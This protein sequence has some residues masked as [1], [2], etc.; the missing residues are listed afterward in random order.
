MLRS[1]ARPAFAATV[2][3]VLAC[4]V[5]NA[6]DIPAKLEMNAFVKIEP[7]QADLVIRV[8]LYLVT[9][10]GFPMNG[11][12]ID[13]AASGP[14][15]ERTLTAIAT[16]IGIW[17]N[18]K[19]LVPSTSTGNLSLPSDRSFQT[20]D[21]A[22]AHVAVP[23]PPGTGIY[24]YQGF[25]D[26]HFTYPITSPQSRFSIQTK[27][28]AELGS[29]VKLI[30]RYLPASGDS[31]AF[32]VT[33]TSGQVSLNPTWYRAAGGFVA[34]GVNHIL[35]GIDHL[36]FLFC[37]VIPFR[38][39]RSLLP[40]ISAFT[41]GHSITLLGTAYN[42][43]PSG[44][45]FPPFVEM[46]IAVSILYMALENIV[47]ANLRRRWLIAGLFGLVHGFGFSYALRDS[48]QFAGSHLLV[49][50]LS[51]NVGI[52]IG[53]LFMLTF[54]VAALWLLFRRMLSERVGVIL[55][56]A[57]VAHTAWHW[58]IA[59]A[60]VF[61]KTDWPQ[62]DAAS[63]TTLAR[64]AAALL[65]ASGIATVIVGWVQRK[66]PRIADTGAANQATPATSQSNG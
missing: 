31:R 57:I 47:G 54:M 41:L 22:V 14:A 43:A 28:A 53:Q 19:R 66:W 12:E 20:Y 23:T 29:F 35:S 32:I 11:R 60:D 6:H 63:L 45:W 62:I 34:L 1:S 44:A 24:G 61:W 5:A 16:S 15:T 9:T 13:L 39:L 65:L 42:L 18:G 58:M 40:V 30:V 8:P 4:L 7:R 49:S 48:L 17:E 56:S 26:A 59:R 55:L 64:W 33:A 38:K 50:L 25:F 37:L 10:E 52:E 46:A 27:V 51:F 3:V 21:E 2:F 36:L